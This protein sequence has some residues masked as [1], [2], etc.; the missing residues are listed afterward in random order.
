MKAWTRPIAFLSDIDASVRR[1][2]CIDLC[3]VLTLLLALFYGADFWYVNV[4]LRILCFSALVVPLLREKPLLWFLLLA[5]LTAGNVRN[6]ITIDNHKYLINYW[7]LVLF[8]VNCVPPEKRPI[9]L[10]TNARVLLLLC[11]GFATLQKVLSEDYLDGRFFQF[12]LLFDERFE[13]FAWLIAGVDWAVLQEFRILKAEMVYGFESGIDLVNIDLIDSGRL[14]FVSSLLT[15]WTLLIEGLIAASFVWRNPNLAV[16][17]LRNWVLILF[18]I[19]TYS[20][21]LVPGFAWTVIIMGLAQLPDGLERFRV[22]YLFLGLVFLQLCE[23]PY[24]KILERVSGVL[25]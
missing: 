23:A 18:V 14:L 11:F 22:A 21:A 25:G 15:G 19:S 6:W 17:Q 1:M 8:L 2:D 24:V 3:S 5:A 13:T 7:V 9:V 4:P 10:R 16:Q 20:V 12:E